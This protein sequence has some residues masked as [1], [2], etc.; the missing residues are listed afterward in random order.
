M[1]RALIFGIVLAVG[2]LAYVLW[3]LVPRGRITRS[4]A[5]SGRTRAVSDE[6]IEAAVRAYRETRAGGGPVCPICGPTQEPDA[7]FC[8]R[9][10]RR[11]DVGAPSA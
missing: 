9:C 5:A 11:L 6:E 7:I 10:G 2:T 1:S 3:P 4:G 8:S